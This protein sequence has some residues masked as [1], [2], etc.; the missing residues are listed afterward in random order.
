MGQKTD[1]AP[2]YLLPGDCW[3]NRLPIGQVMQEL[4]N[5]KTPPYSEQVKCSQLIR[6]ELIMK[7]M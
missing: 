7:T 5:N 3:E 1:E 2:L 6:G 4:W